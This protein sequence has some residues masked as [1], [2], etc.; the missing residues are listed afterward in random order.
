MEKV[1]SI[2]I[3]VIMFVIS[4]IFLISVFGQTLGL[5][6]AYTKM[7]CFGYCAMKIN[8]PFG[9][10]LSIPGLGLPGGFCGC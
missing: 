9:S 1:T 4:A 7:W 10:P 8:M 2:I 5:G 3:A 6:E